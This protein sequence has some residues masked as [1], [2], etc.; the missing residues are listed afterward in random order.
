MPRRSVLT[1]NTS[2]GGYPSFD[3]SRDERSCEELLFALRRC[4]IRHTADAVLRLPP[5]TDEVV[6][7]AHARLPR[8]PRFFVSRGVRSTGGASKQNTS[9]AAARATRQSADAVL[10][11]PP[12]IKE[13]LPESAWQTVPCAFCN[14]AVKLYR[15]LPLASPA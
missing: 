12:K 3:P 10:R 7:G 2:S 5:K 13:L 1:T 9:S 14:I 4:M 15:S 8:K 6:P 11:L